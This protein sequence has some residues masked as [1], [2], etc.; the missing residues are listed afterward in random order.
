MDDE[1]K[2]AAS[3]GTW[4][5]TAAEMK[6]APEPVRLHQLL[7]FSLELGR[8]VESGGREFRDQELELSHSPRG[9]LL[10]D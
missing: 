7:G 8:G 3:M 2:L 6:G 10:H 9:R 5:E 1:Y 4:R